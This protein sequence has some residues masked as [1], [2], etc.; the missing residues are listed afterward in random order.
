LAAVPA[1]PLD[2]SSRTAAHRWLAA[3]EDGLVFRRERRILANAIARAIATEHHSRR[4]IEAIHRSLDRSALRRAEL[5]GGT[6]WPSREAGRRSQRPVRID[7]EPAAWERFKNQATRTGTTVGEA[8]GR[9]PADPSALSRVLGHA[10]VTG[11]RRVMS[12]R[13]A[14]RSTTNAGESSASK[15]VAQASRSPAPSDCSPNARLTLEGD[16]PSA[17]RLSSEHRGQLQ[18]CRRGRALV[19][20]RAVPAAGPSS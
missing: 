14:S 17:D 15:L 20:G 19:A 6:Y 18:L 10:P 4:H 11:T 13:C 16:R 12:R 5:D 9:L 7:V 2:D 1:P 3:V 8:L